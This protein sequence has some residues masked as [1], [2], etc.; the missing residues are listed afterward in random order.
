MTLLCGVLL[1]LGG[2]LT[3][4]FAWIVILTVVV[5]ICR[6]PKRTRNIA[7]HFSDRKFVAGEYHQSRIALERLAGPVILLGAGKKAKPGL[8]KHLA[9]TKRVR[10]SP[11]P[12][13][14]AANALFA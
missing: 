9:V 6:I 12:L 10:Q 1:L 7:F 2:T 14:T 11:V 4:T 3:D 8:R 13:R 5:S